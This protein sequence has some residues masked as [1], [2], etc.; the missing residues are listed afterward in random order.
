[1]RTPTHLARLALLPAALALVATAATGCA[2][3][4]EDAAA[5]SED[6]LRTTYGDLLDTL[7]DADWDRWFSARRA[8]VAGFDRICGDTICGG[9][10]PNLSTVRLTCAST[11]A[12][13]KMKAC[14]WILGGSTSWVDQRTGKITT[15]VRAFT[16]PVTV[17]GNA[18]QFLDA[19]EQAGDR[20]LDAVI[21]G[22][23]GS[24]YDALT[25]CFSG[26]VSSPVPEQ[27]ATFWSDLEGYLWE[28]DDDAA[29]TFSDA[30]RRLN[31]GFDD[32]C[33]DSFCEGE[34]P[35]ITGLGFV[36]TVNRNTKKVARCSWSF[37]YG[38]TDVTSRG[39]IRATTTTK[40]CN[41][42]VNAPA[43]DFVRVLGG[44]DPLRAPLPGK[45]TSIYDALIGCL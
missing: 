16:C 27:T 3:G 1:M 4:A 40:T 12:A 22:T 33:G 19:L 5:S 13:K 39:A 35:D 29:S 32:V 2:T 30:R 8:I 10:Y 9:D 41:V 20:A 26:V 38:A 44:D 31:E 42:D 37:A 6:E 7:E 34:Y 28:T 17:G 25:T 43:S 18:K 21:P 23:Q 11:Y 24:F 14:T 45:T 15:D 36:C